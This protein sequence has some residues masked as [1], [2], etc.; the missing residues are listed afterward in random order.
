MFT[1]VQPETKIADVSVL[2]LYIEFSVQ[3]LDHDISTERTTETQP[4]DVFKH[5]VKKLNIVCEMLN[6][7][8]VGW[9]EDSINVYGPQF[10]NNVA[11]YM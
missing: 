1:N 2:G 4:R 9:S 5:M 11:K 3:K 6:L 10:M 8:N 7:S